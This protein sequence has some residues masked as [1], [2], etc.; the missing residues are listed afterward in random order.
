MLVSN[1]FS[2]WLFVIPR[3]TRILAA[4][5]YFHGR[6][7]FQSII[8]LIGPKTDL[9]LNDGFLLQNYGPDPPWYMRHLANKKSDGYAQAQKIH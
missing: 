3:L 7:P 6:F 9:F 4:N 2:G 8:R 1:D 5:P